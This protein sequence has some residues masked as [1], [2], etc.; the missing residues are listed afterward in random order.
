[1]ASA[2]VPVDDRGDAADDHAPQDGERQELDRL[3]HRPV[4]GC[5]DDDLGPVGW[6]ARG[7]QQHG[8]G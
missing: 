5:L 3:A 7:Q 2:P 8:E 1:M 4:V 6:F